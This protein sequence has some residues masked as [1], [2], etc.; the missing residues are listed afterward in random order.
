[1][2]GVFHKQKGAA[3]GSPV[4]PIVAN[5]YVEEDKT[6]EVE[7]IRKVLKMNCYKPWNFKT[8]KPRKIQENVNTRETNRRQHM[9]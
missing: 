4:S 6:K 1:M 9:L 8:I 2:T 3:M 7:H 5:L